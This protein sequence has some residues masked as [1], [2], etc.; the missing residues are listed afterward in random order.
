MQ[1]PIATATTATARAARRRRTWRAIRVGLLAAA[2]LFA[3]LCIAPVPRWCLDLVGAPRAGLARYGGLRVGWLA[4]EFRADAAHL[5]RRLVARGVSATLRAQGRLVTVDIPDLREVD[6]PRVLALLR[7]PDAVEIHAL[8]PDGALDRRALFDRAQIE[9]AGV[10]DMIGETP[11][12]A[13]MLWTTDPERGRRM[14]GVRVAITVDHQVRWTGELWK[15]FGDFFVLHPA[16][17]DLAGP[18]EALDGGALHGGAIA[19]AVLVA[20]TDLAP[21][22]WAARAMIAIAGGV[23][24]ALI[25]VLLSAV[26][27]RSRRRDASAIAGMRPG[28]EPE[29]APVE[30]PAAGVSIA[31]GLAR[32]PC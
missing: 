22:A 18:A 10:T 30:I 28:C 27:T 2:A 12:V 6:V 15:L 1:L 3:V 11:M 31:G 19:S 8:G 24:G 17:G 23:A 29:R 21:F 32:R 14:R 16:G 13:F 4:H 25:S 20:P 26:S 7:A 9:G 5:E